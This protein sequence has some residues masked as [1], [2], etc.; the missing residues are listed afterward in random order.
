MQAWSKLL[1][2]FPCEHD[3]HWH[4]RNS[5][6]LHGQYYY[7][8]LL[9]QILRGTIE[10][11]HIKWVEFI[12]NLRAFFPQGQR[13]LS[14]IIRCPKW[15]SVCKVGFDCTVGQ[16][17][18]TLGIWVGR[19]GGR[20]ID[21]RYLKERGVYCHN[22]NKFTNMFCKN[23]KRVYN[24]LLFLIKKKKEMKYQHTLHFL[25]TSRR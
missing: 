24:L 20:L 6:A 12:E 3:F 4:W 14:V 18:L 21:R 19:G 9:K 11:V 17:F 10:S 22:L 13:K 25:T 5:L 15:V 7:S 1:L 23:I 8:T 2:A 16:A